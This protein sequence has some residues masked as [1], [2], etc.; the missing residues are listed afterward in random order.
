M[1]KGHVL[2]KVQVLPGLL[3]SIMNR[4]LSFS[5]GRTAQSLGVA[6]K[7]KMDLTLFRFKTNFGDIQGGLKTE[8]GGKKRGGFHADNH[9]NA[10]S[11]GPPGYANFHSKRKR[12]LKMS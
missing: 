3:C 5:E 11:Y 8:G 7:V 9:L 1:E 10:D 2:E 6:G 12:R 4:L